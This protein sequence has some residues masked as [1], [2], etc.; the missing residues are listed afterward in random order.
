MPVV[1]GKRVNINKTRDE[2]TEEFLSWF[3]QF[4]DV[5]ASDV[6]LFHLYV[7]GNKK[8]SSLA[9]YNFVITLTG[10]ELVKKGAPDDPVEGSNVT[11]MCIVDELHD[12]HPPNWFHQDS[13][14]HYHPLTLTNDTSVELTTRNE[15][16]NYEMKGKI[17][18]QPLNKGFTRI[19]LP[20]IE[21]SDIKIKTVGLH[22]VSNAIDSY[23]YSSNLYLTNV[24]LDTPYTKFKCE[25][26]NTFKEISFKVK[27]KKKF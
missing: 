6:I 2:Y 24:T 22:S 26:N 3:S 21:T 10:L 1:N 9:N 13:N 27:G 15:D 11:F 18:E 19:F 16:K 17:S 7:A 5:N 12:P 25:V 4:D 8:L 23:T 20:L 14:G